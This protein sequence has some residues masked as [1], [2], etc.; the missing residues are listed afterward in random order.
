MD[1]D[2]FLRS[3]GVS[4]PKCRGSRGFYG[5]L[6]H[7]FSTYLEAVSELGSSPLAS[8]IRKRA[9]TVETLQCHLLSAVCARFEGACDDGAAA[10]AAGLQL[11]QGELEDLIS[12]PVAPA[13]TGP[14]Y[15]MRLDAPKQPVRADLFHIPFEQRN[16]TSPYRYSLAGAPCLYLGGSL[17]V[18]W[19]ELLRGCPPAPQERVAFCSFRCRSGETLRFLNFAYRPSVLAEVVRKRQLLGPLDPELVRLFASYAVCWPILAACS[20]TVP[21]QGALHPP[22]YVIPQMLMEWLL[23]EYERHHLDGVR[24]F[25]MQ[26]KPRLDDGEPD[27]WVYDTASFALPTKTPADR[28]YCRVLMKKLVMSEPR[29]AHLSQPT[30]LFALEHQLSHLAESDF[31]D[32]NAVARPSA[33]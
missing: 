11:V 26:M 21:G 27:T 28:G 12:L 15:R 25:S 16:M 5:Y 19:A 22:E 31:D 18:C 8:S 2:E 29:V 14:M 33:L 6:G 17:R 4:L 7:V 20:L 10:L 32:I 24:Y 23:R 9:K 1:A 13:N 3:D 30:E